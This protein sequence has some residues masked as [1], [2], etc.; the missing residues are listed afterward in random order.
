MLR[1]TMEYR[2]RVTKVQGDR[3]RRRLR[4]LQSDSDEEPARITSNASGCVVR[5]VSP[6]H[7]APKKIRRRPKIRAPDETSSLDSGSRRSG[8][9]GH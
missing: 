2:S 7:V 6:F 4:R 5:P 3:M 9:Y 1:G 8:R